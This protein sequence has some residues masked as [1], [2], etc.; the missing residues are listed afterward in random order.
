M[1]QRYEFIFHDWYV[2]SIMMRS[3]GSIEGPMLNINADLN[4]HKLTEIT[5]EIGNV[6]KI[7][8]DSVFFY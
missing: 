8:I 2:V 7:T 6:K 5:L 1:Y 3:Y 4:Q